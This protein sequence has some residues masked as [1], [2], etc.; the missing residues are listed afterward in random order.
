[1]W[2]ASRTNQ[3]RN[4]FSEK[5]HIIGKLHM[6]HPKQGWMEW[7]LCKCQRKCQWLLNIQ[8]RRASKERTTVRPNGCSLPALK[9]MSSKGIGKRY[10][11]CSHKKESTQ[12]MPP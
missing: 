11:L 12:Q 2:M 7:D 5:D 4:N 6:R 9:Y 3:A 8:Q 1:M 10:V